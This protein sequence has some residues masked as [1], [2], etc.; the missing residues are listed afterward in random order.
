MSTTRTRTRTRT[1]RNTHKNPAAEAEAAANEREREAG[2]NHRLLRLQ[3]IKPCEQQQ[4]QQQQQQQHKKQKQRHFLLHP[5]V[6]EHVQVVAVGE[7]DALLRQLGQELLQMQAMADDDGVHRALLAP[8]HRLMRH[9]AGQIFE[10]A[11]AVADTVPEHRAVLVDAPLV[12]AALLEDWVAFSQTDKV[13]DASEGRLGPS[14]GAAEGAVD[15]RAADLL[16]DAASQGVRLLSAQRGQAVRRLR[17]AHIQR[18]LSVAAEEEPHDDHV[19]DDEEA[20][21]VGDEWRRIIR[22]GRGGGGERGGEDGEELSADEATVVGAIRLNCL[23]TFR[24]F[25][26]SYRT[27]FHNT[28]NEQGLPE[29]ASGGSRALRA[30][31]AQVDVAVVQLHDGHATAAAAATEVRYARY[32]WY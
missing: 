10:V 15:E 14:Q 12:E 27:V 18:A 11:V 4:Q 17:G 7:E 29:R 22:K 19:D 31:A 20:D 2:T 28:L 30:D 16:V 6:V 13:E 32:A 1:T 9:L 25:H 24:S 21:E 8:A 5:R 23:S 26:C 3:P